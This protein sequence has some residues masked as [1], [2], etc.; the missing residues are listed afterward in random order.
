MIKLVIVIPIV[1]KYT[2]ASNFEEY[3]FAG[4]LR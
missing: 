2:G 1:T 3:Q 4:R